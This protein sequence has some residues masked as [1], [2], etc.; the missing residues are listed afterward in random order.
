MTTSLKCICT[1]PELGAHDNV[2]RCIC[3]STFYMLII[4]ILSKNTINY[5]YTVNIKNTMK[6]ASS[7]V[8]IAIASAKSTYGFAPSIRAKSATTTAAASLR[9]LATGNSVY[10]AARVRTPTELGLFGFSKAERFNSPAKSSGDISEKEVRALFELWNSALAT[11]D[12]RIVASR[13]TK[14]RR[15]FNICNSLYDAVCFATAP[16]SNHIV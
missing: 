7:I 11:G 15:R 8:C 9:D 10:T 3:C 5:R 16:K 2:R 13:Y 14:V 1:L 6:F 12:S 4:R